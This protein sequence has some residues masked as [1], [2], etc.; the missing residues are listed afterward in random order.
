MTLNPTVFYPPAQ[1]IT[2]A[3]GGSLISFPTD[4]VPAL[5][6][7]P[8]RAQDLFQ[9]KQRSTQKPLI[10]MGASQGDLWPYVDTTGVPAEIIDQW[11]QL[12]A[13]YWPGAVTFVLP[14]GPAG[15][16]WA[17]ALNPENPTTL[18]LRVPNHDL[19]RSLLQQTGPLATTSA[20]R[21]G[22]PALTDLPSIAQAFPQVAVLD[23]GAGLSGGSGQASTVVQWQDDGWQVLRSGAVV[24]DLPPS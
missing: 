14:V 4:T 17:A 15:Q 12:M 23:P 24:L 8:D 19:A 13:Q 6:I 18:G 3:Q 5:A 21:S 9:A 20:N 16:P 22:E 11:Q 2:I 7:R 10:L 1:L